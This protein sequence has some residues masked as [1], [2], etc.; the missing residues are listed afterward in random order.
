[1]APGEEGL[2]AAA[3]IGG[4]FIPLLPLI[5]YFAKSDASPFT[6]HHLAQATNFQI[7]MIIAYFV[8]G[9]LMFVIIGILTYLV[10]LGLAIYF[11]IKA[12]SEAKKG[13]WFTYPFSIPVAK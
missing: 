6:K 1:M 12:N 13:V 9:L 4:A 8:S 3:H 5:L 11:G 2:V 10:A 7:A